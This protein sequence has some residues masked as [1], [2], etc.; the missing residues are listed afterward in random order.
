MGSAKALACFAI[1][2]GLEQFVH[3]RVCAARMCNSCLSDRRVSSSIFAAWKSYREV[4]SVARKKT[5]TPYL[6]TAVGSF[7][8]IRLMSDSFVFTFSRIETIPVTDLK[9]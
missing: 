2:F 3:F 6:V 7:F 9:K 1:L 4:V 8:L 5:V